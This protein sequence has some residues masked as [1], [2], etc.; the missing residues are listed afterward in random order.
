M[1]VSD[2]R[3]MTVNT[4]NLG[5]GIT[6]LAIAGI[7]GA[8]ALTT[9]PLG[10]LTDMGPAFF[11]VT[12]CGILAVIGIALV[13]RSFAGVRV[14]AFEVIAWRPMLIISGAILFFGT[15]I[16]ETGVAP[17]VFVTTCVCALAAKGTSTRQAA[18]TG[19]V[20]AVLCVLVFI[21]GVRLPLPV[22][23]T[24]FTW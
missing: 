1:G 8:S 22:F 2:E 10:S 24:W 23:G 7:Y 5:A 4:K 12:L 15:F 19:A 3:D 13:A 11:P 20:M 21:Y 17:A 9:L 18:A 14:T 16:R 6:F